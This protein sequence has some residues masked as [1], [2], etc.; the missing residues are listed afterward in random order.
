MICYNPDLYWR[1]IVQARG[2]RI[3]RIFS[4]VLPMT[5]WA[6]AVEYYGFDIPFSSTTSIV[7]I[8]GSA[9][10]FLLVFRINASNERFWEGRK[11]WGG[12]IN[13]SRNL[14]RATQIHL[15]NDRRKQEEI[16]V[17]IIVFA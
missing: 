6:F 12:M 4:R 15:V 8:I 17:W 13:T 11:L 5:L 7:A 1:Y 3:E 14:A 9:L 16:V 2:T 10:G